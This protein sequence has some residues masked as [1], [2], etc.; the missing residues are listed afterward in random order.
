M[1]LQQE[2]HEMNDKITVA[3]LELKQL[4]EEVQKLVTRH[5]FLPVKLIAYGFAACIF[6]SVLAALLSKVFIK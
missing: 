6:T 2:V 1:N 3:S 5:E 4:K